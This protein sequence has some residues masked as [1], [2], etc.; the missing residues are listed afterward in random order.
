MGSGDVMQM[1]PIKGGIVIPAGGAVILQPGGKHIM[2]IGLTQEL[3]VGTTLDF[4]LTFAQSG[5]ITLTVPVQAPPETKPT[6]PMEAT[7]TS[8]G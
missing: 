4:T 2:M 8:G 3:A 6:M 1:S 5:E 7:P